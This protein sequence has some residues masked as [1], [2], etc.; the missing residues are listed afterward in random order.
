MEPAHWVCQDLANTGDRD[1]A[2]SEAGKPASPMKVTNIPYYSQ[3]VFAF[4]GCACSD[5]VMS[6]G[7]TITSEQAMNFEKDSEFSGSE[8]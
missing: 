8:F 4:D 5:Q 2:G 6:S 3:H 1:V 7:K